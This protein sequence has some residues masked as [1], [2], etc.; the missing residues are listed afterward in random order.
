MDLQKLYQQI[1]QFI[2]HCLLW[3]RGQGKWSLGLILSIPWRLKLI[4]VES[5]GPWLSESDPGMQ[6][7]IYDEEFEGWQMLNTHLMRGKF[8]LWV[9]SKLLF[10]LLVFKS[11]THCLVSLWAG[12]FCNFPV[13]NV[14]WCCTVSLSIFPSF[15]VFSCI[16]SKL[17]HCKSN[18]GRSFGKSANPWILSCSSSF[19]FWAEIKT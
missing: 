7:R 13:V 5:S 19:S 17:L 3:K 15:S 18:A 11:L 2:V 8:N 4:H 12:N 14:V 16:G 9:E 1:F 6:G 10:S